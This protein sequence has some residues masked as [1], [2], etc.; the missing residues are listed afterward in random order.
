MP[1]EV[2]LRV[3][4]IGCTQGMP[5]RITYANRQGDEISDRLEDFVDDED[6][7]DSSSENN[8][9]TYTESGSDQDSVIQFPPKMDENW[10]RNGGERDKK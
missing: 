7:G 1:Q 9:N 4:Q 6:D 8:D 5:S 2:I 10:L 3:T